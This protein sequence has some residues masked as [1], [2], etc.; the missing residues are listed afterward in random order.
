MKNNVLNPFVGKWQILGWDQNTV[1]GWQKLKEHQP[2]EYTWEFT[3]EGKLIEKITGQDDFITEFSYFPDDHKLYIDR[4][5]Y[6]DDGYMFACY[7]DIYRTVIVTD[8]LL[9][10]YDL[11]DVEV[12]PDDYYF[13]LNMK[14]IQ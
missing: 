8:C 5:D 13:R 3:P 1:K 10:L 6:C 4:S 14:K 9:C 11:E 7:N 12:E 2:Q